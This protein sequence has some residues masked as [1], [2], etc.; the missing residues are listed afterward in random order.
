MLSL[1][2]Y[3]TTSG[4]GGGGGGIVEG[5]DF[6]GGQTPFIADNVNT[7]FEITHNLGAVPRFFTL[8]TTQPI[9]ANHL[10]RTISFPD[11]N[12]MR[13][14]FQNPPLSGEDANYVWIVFK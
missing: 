1:I 5:T 14:T 4:G 3:E 11:G 7:W 12:T 9:A 8:T 13:I 2:S 6:A 10:A